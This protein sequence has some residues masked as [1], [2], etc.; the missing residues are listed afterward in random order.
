M[1][2]IC[3][4]VENVKN[5]YPFPEVKKHLADY[6]YQVRANRNNVV[7]WAVVYA[8]LA[9]IASLVIGP[10]TAFLV[11]THFSLELQGFYYTFGSLLQLRFLADMGLGQTLVQFSSHEW[12]GLE[13]DASGKIVGNTANLSRLLSLVRISISWY[14]ALAALLVLG[15]GVIGYELFQTSGT[16]TVD[17]FEPWFVLCILVGLSFVTIPFFSLLQG[18]GFIND[19]WFYRLLVQIF[20]GVILWAAILAG[21]ELWSMAVSVLFTTTWGLFFLSLRHRKFIKALFS[22]PPSLDRIGWKDQV[23]PVQ[24]RIAIVW[25]TSTFIA[26]LLTPLVFRIKGP[27][28]AGRVGLTLSLSMVLYALVSNW[29]FTKAPVF[30]HLI[31]KK[32]FNELDGLFWHSLVM[33]AVTLILGVV[34]GTSVIFIM[35]AIESPLAQRVVGPLPAAMF[36]LGSSVAAIGACFGV[37]LRAHK[38]EPLTIVY[39]VTSLS[40]LGICYLGLKMFGVLGMAV[41]YAAVM[42]VFQLPW[43]FYAFQK[44]RHAWHSSAVKLDS[45]TNTY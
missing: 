22:K 41:S 40:V 1:E 36:L 34:G 12:A 14:V 28:V 42:A 33:S 27:E 45:T 37:Y 29:I 5:K 26:Q 2:L 3:S 13:W 21:L 18:C 35:N 25:I 7:S 4:L 8:S 10:I 44:S 23:W 9:N 11:A 6:V 39:A 31:A 20:S 43:V 16:T 30:G 15:L 17:W 38:K 32:Q 24:W 19:Y